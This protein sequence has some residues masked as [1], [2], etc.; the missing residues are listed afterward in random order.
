MYGGKK[1]EYHIFRA[2]KQEL[3]KHR[4]DKS[5]NFARQVKR[6]EEDKIDDISI[7]ISPLTFVRPL[8]QLMIKS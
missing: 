5:T 2:N 8:E 4:N 3:N 7:S 6:K 1:R